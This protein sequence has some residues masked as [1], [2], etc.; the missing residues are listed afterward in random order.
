[1]RIISAAVLLALF[2]GALQGCAFLATPL[3]TGAIG[4]AQL[5]IKGAELQQ[6]IRKANVQKAID[7]PFEQVWSAAVT[8][9]ADLEIAVTRSQENELGDGGI[10]EGVVKSTR[11]KIVVAK[12]TEKIT[13]IGIWAN[14]DKALA[15]LLAERINDQAKTK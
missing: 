8:V 10:V 3:A 11:I 14:G 15:E 5:A 13:K 7:A 4:G 2:A 12:L 1:M 6:Q 9:P